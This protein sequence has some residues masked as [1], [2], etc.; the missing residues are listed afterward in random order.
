VAGAVQLQRHAPP[1][2]SP[3][4]S[5]MPTW[6]TA[7]AMLS[8]ASIH[9]NRVIVLAATVLADEKPCDGSVAHDGALSRREFGGD[10]KDQFMNQANI[11]CVDQEKNCRVASDGVRSQFAC[12]HPSRRERKQLHGEQVSEVE[13]HEMRRC[14]GSIVQEMTRVARDDVDGQVAHR[15]AQPHR[16]QRRQGFEGPHAG[17]RRSRTRMVMRTANTPSENAAN[18]SGVFLACDTGQLSQCH[19]RKSRIASAISAA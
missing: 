4:I 19:F 17:G 2:C 6:S 15:I 16:P 10:T 18:R 1:H 9:P 7:P 5:R 3:V 11:D 13:P 12:R 8:S 14:V